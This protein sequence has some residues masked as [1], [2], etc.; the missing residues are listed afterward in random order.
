[1]GL[2]RYRRHER[3]DGHRRPAGYFIDADQQGTPDAWP[4][5]GLTIIDFRNSHLS[6]A[7]TWYAMALLLVAGMG[8]AIR[9]RIRGD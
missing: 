1:M 4:R 9:D 5:G 2:A 8:W 3:G 7:L 6:Y